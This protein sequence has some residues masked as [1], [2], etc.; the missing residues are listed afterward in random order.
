V[1]Q[2][3]QLEPGQLEV[4]VTEVDCAAIRIRH[5]AYSVGV[6]ETLDARGGLILAYL[7]RQCGMARLGGEMWSDHKVAVILGCAE[8][9]TNE[10]S[11]LVT[12]AVNSK[13]VPILEE[14]LSQNLRDTS[15][16]A[17]LAAHGK[18]E[19][20]LEAIGSRGFCD[21]PS[22]QRKLFASIIN[23][24]GG[25]KPARGSSRAFEQRQSTAGAAETFMWSHIDDE[26][27]LDAICRGIGC[28]PRTLISYFHQL[29]GMGPVRFLKILRLNRAR[30]ALT[31]STRSATVFDVAADNGFWHMGH[32][33]SSYRLLFAETPLETLRGRN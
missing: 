19:S 31:A 27:T 10:A 7:E 8:F 6:R 26:F 20:H 13:L 16:F 2:L 17:I 29:Y 30:A 23:T 18:L 5:V 33:S 28:G 1:S 21:D 11:V 25:V 32:F 4:T 15:G 14:L 12:V 24:V 9:S 22:E 3:A